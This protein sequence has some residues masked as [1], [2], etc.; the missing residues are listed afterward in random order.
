[1]VLSI[2]SSSRKGQRFCCG[3]AGEG[4]G[5]HQHHYLFTRGYAL[6]L[7][8]PLL[9][10]RVPEALLVEL[11]VVFLLFLLL[12][13]VLLDTHCVL[14]LRHVRTDFIGLPLLPLA[15]RHCWVGGREESKGPVTH[16]RLATACRTANSYATVP[17]QP[18]VW[19]IMFTSGARYFFAI[20]QRGPDHMSEG[21]GVYTSDNELTL[22]E[23]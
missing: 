7:E 15:L 17:Y 20:F 18:S 3:A 23:G 8:D 22:A 13:P 11:R 2:K 9:V 10:V 12:L 4:G 6:L 19:C 16:T 14:L 21:T 1:M 5:V